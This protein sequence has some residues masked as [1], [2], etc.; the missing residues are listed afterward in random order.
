MRTR[1]DVPMMSLELIRRRCIKG[2]IAHK[3]GIDEA[4]SS[5][6][7]ET[8]AKTLISIASIHSGVSRIQ[9]GEAST[10]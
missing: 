7:T 2:P 5:S 3:F 8:V 4:W 6:E 9:N 1:P 10:L